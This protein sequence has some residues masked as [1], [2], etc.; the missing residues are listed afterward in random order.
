MEDQSGHR[1]HISDGQIDG[2]EYEA[3]GVGFRNANAGSVA[4]VLV[5]ANTSES[6]GDRMFY[7]DDLRVIPE[8][9]AATMLLTLGGALAMTRRRSRQ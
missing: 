4:S 8:P 1:L 7:V 2:F 6:G 5:L 9:T 3:T